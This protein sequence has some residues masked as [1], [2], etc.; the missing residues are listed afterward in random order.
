MTGTTGLEPAASAVTVTTLDNSLK[1]GGMD[2]A[3]PPLKA[4]NLNWTR[5]GLATVTAEQRQ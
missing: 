1:S 2:N 5:R 4:R 3:L